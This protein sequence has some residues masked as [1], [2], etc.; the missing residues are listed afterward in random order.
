MHYTVGRDEVWDKKNFKSMQIS[1][2][3]G[4][5]EQAAKLQ[6]LQL[7]EDRSFSGFV[8]HTSALYLYLVGA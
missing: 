7:F 8:I 3:K 6:P 5:T 1:I 2:K 4:K